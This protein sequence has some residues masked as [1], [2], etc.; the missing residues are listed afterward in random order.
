MKNILN[1]NT[2]VTNTN[3]KGFIILVTDILENFQLTAFRTA[4]MGPVPMIS[5]GTPAAA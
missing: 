3:E 4:G 5:G 2:K 1:Y